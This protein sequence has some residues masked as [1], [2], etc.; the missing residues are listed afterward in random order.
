MT[1]FDDYRFEKLRV[2]LR[3]HIQEVILWEFGIAFSEENVAS[4]GRLLPL[5]ADAGGTAADVGQICFSCRPLFKKN[6]F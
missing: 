3:C 4:A 6:F 5:A 1:K 2:I